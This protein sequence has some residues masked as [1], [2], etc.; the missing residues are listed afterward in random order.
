MDKDM[1]KFLVM[2]YIVYPILCIINWWLVTNLDGF[3]NGDKDKEGLLFF[4][5]ML[6]LIAPFGCVVMLILTVVLILSYILQYVSSFILP[7]M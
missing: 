1:V 7:Y 3:A 6:W 2:C 4:A 5:L